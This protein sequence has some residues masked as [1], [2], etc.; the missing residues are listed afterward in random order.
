MLIFTCDLEEENL[1]KPQNGQSGQQNNYT[2]LLK[3]VEH[4]SANVRETHIEEDTFIFILITEVR[5]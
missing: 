1:R 2:L 4:T 3:I 5:Y